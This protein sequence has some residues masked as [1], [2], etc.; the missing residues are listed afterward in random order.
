MCWCR[1]LWAVLCSVSSFRPAVVIVVV[2]LLP[3]LLIAPAIVRLWGRKEEGQ[4]TMASAG[5]RRCADSRPELL[6]SMYRTRVWIGCEE[7]VCDRAASMAKGGDGVELEARWV[8]HWDESGS[9]RGVCG[10]WVMQRMGDVE[11]M[12]AHA[13]VGGLHATIRRHWR[14]HVHRCSVSAC[15]VPLPAANPLNLKPI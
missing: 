1:L 14:I 13:A 11:R 15:Q 12:H 10:R 2:L 8:D 5:Q 9:E 4:G 7:G 6:R 3:L